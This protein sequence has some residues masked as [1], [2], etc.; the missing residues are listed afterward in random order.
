MRRAAV[1]ATAY[2]SHEDQ[3]A[4]VDAVAEWILARV[5]YRPD[6]LLS[7]WLQQPWAVLSEIE[8][9]ERPALDCDDL[10]LL[11]LSMLSA[12]GFQTSLVVVA[13]QPDRVFDH[14]YGVVLI[15]GRWE[16]LDLTAGLGGRQ[17]RPEYRAAMVA[18]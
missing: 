9:G 16:A 7:E 11:S 15:S 12:I 10:T 8:R 18:V 5:D 1:E 14:V 13:S 6:P 2:L 17:P 3:A 4:E